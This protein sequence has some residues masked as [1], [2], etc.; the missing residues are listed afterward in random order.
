MDIGKIGVLAGLICSISAVV[1]YALSLRGNR[2]VLLAARSALALVAM[3][4]VFTF[5]RLMWIVYHQQFQYKYVY[6]YS[7]TTL[8]LPWNIAASWA[9][10]EGS[11]VLWAFWT[12]IIG[13]LVAWK[14]GKWESRVMPI[15]VSVL[16]FLFGILVWLSPFNV[17]HRGAGPNDYPLDLMW[18]IPNGKGLNPSLQNY[19]MA[20]HP[21]TIFFGFASLAV[22]FCYAIASLIWREYETWAPRVMPYVLM[23]TATLGVGLFMGGYWAYETQGWH[24]F[25]AWDPVEN[26][27]LFPWLGGLGLLHG[28]V[29]QKS[30]GG[31]ARTNLFLAI[32]AWILFLYGT[33]LTRSGVMSDFSVHAFVSLESQP[34]KLLMVM[35]AVYGLGGIGLL[36]W[37]WRKVPG[38]PIS[39]KVLSRDTAMVLAVTL[40]IAAC[41]VVLLGTSWP[42]LAQWIP[43]MRHVPG[44]PYDLEKK[45]AVLL[46][47]A[48]NKVCSFLLIPALVLM[49]AVPFLA[50]GKTNVD[51]FLW[52]VIVPWLSAIG[53]GAFI[54]WFTLI[55]AQKPFEIST[56]R[57][58]VVAIGTLGVFAALANIGLAIKLL[59]VKTVTMG[60]W[61]AHVGIGILF[62]GTV[63][64]NV[65]EQTSSF[66]LFEG[67]PPVKTPFGY[68]IQYVG[69]THDETQR[70]AEKA[71]DPEEA[72]RLQDKQ[73]REW[74]DFGHAVLVRV[75]P[76]DGGAN[77]ANAD[78]G[79][80]EAGKADPRSFIA[81]LPVFKTQQLAMND[82]NTG[83]TTMRWPYIHKEIL[84]DFYVLV[85]SDPKLMRVNATL[86]PG[87]TKPIR[88]TE[89]L[90][91]Y[92]KFYM[93]GTPG[94]EGTTMGA[95]MDL[96][97][98]EGKRIPIRPGIRVGDMSPV[99]QLIPEANGAVILDRSDGKPAVDIA[100]K[101]VTAE[102]ELPNA[103]AFWGMPIA[104]TNKPGINL[105]WLGVLLMGAGTL[106]AM[107]RRSA[108][109]RKGALILNAA[110][111][112]LTDGPSPVVPV[113][114]T[115]GASKDPPGPTRHKQ[116]KK[117]RSA[118]S[119]K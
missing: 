31:M 97:T 107:V 35:I 38:R 18:P 106:C 27:S 108:E 83:P 104:V 84:R 86:V 16:C 26:A 52:K 89:Y 33:F 48:Y 32:L 91:N 6:E 55:Q 66:N 54:V 81:A 24:G 62:L 37:R 113:A 78:S 17:I 25:W 9:G 96:I 2:K 115:N 60:G 43:W 5:A 53:V 93:D 23:T 68:S 118:A 45:G 65:Y 4:A 39:D 13:G 40:M 70:L 10:Q 94:S 41:F 36:A 47:V 119:T 112:G 11:F 21:P 28:L 88:G 74:W 3:S 30:R 76:I 90:V 1:L 114:S 15:Y 22:P 49:G 20:I 56:P 103:P 101:Q 29:V 72:A 51:K 64:T 117:A 14:A 99:N 109:V 75:T 69:W 57:T 8:K 111:A 80:S 100:T 87:E 63:I 73:R 19:W 82:G 98:P 71:T 92:K 7:D 44:M 61:L 77:V 79:D 105:V 95:D 116:A 34:L 50:W 12:A 42:I 67:A 85:A 102:F 58:L 46:P 59:R 110:S